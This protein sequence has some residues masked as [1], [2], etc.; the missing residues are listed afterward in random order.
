MKARYLIVIFFIAT[1]FGIVQIAAHQG[2][3]RSQESI[4][5]QTDQAGGDT[6]AEL[7]QLKSYV[8]AHM[9]T[10]TSVYLSASYNRAVTAAQAATNSGVSGTVYAQAQAACSKHSDSIVLSHCVS[11]YLASH[12]QPAANPQPVALP[13]QNDFVHA[14]TSPNWT[15]DI[16]GLTF[17]VALSALVLAIYIKVIQRV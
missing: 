12:S 1:L 6:S 2:H 15:P 8:S 10:S 17:L 14:Y 9:L 16:T 11:A 4:I 7:D 13:S 3:V 5:T